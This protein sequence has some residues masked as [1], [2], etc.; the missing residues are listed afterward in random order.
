MINLLP[1]ETRQTILY[2][3]RNT[4]LLHWIMALLAGIA[5]IVVVVVVGHVFI[6]ENTKNISSQVDQAQAEL[7]AQK[8]DETAKRVE[9]I[10][11]SLK[12]VN[13][14]LSKQ[15]VF[16]ELLRQ[17]GIVMP[18]GTSLANLTFS[19]L[20]GGM[21][22]QVASKDY[23]TATQVQVNLSDPTNKIFEKVDIIS[24]TCGD[25]GQGDYPCTGSYRALFA[26]DNPFTFIKPAAGATP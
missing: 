10:T 6:N 20:E 26:K 23:Q 5:G 15:I 1:P 17:T 18:S 8:L 13:Q 25:A 9:D 11:G 16:S 22:L 3:R 14:V 7:K 4:K 19:K 2:A 24:I 21:D 12:L